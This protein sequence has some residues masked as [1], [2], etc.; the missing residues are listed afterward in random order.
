MAT[1]PIDNILRREGGYSNNPLDKGGRTDKGISEKANPEAWADGVVTD[2]E[3]R[4][5]YEQKYVKG[6]GF[7]KINDPKLREQLIDFGVNSGPMIAIKKL[8]ELLHVPADGVL[9]PKTLSVLPNPLEYASRDLN[10]ALVGAR[11]RMIG[12]IVTNV[13]SQLKYL[14][15]WLNRALEFLT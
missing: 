5:I 10:N 4:A 12:K 11:I 14:N 9:G 2:A 13:P 6:P 7:D 3:A 15:G 8:Q 1:D